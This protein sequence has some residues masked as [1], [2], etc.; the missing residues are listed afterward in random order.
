MKDIVVHL[1]GSS[2]DRFR[3]QCAEALAER[4]NAHLTGLLVHLRPE[5]FAMP[6]ASVGS[7]ASAFPPYRRG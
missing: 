1:T 7:P 4:F 3:L 2:E 6:D 5:V